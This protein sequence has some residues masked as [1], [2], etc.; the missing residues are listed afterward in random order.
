MVVAES[1]LQCQ[2]EVLSTLNTLNPGNKTLYLCPWNKGF[3]RALLHFRLVKDLHTCEIVPEESLY[4]NRSWQH[5][6][7]HNQ[8]LSK[9]NVKIEEDPA[10]A[11]D[12]LSLEVSDC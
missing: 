12:R 5:R 9:L 6:L 8:A 2:K 11:S 4:L 7:H 3:A 10:V 1:H